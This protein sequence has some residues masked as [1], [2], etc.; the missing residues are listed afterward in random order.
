MLHFW[1]QNDPFAPNSFSQRDGKMD[2]GQTLCIFR[3]IPAGDRCP[4]NPQSKIGM[5]VSITG[6]VHL[7]IAVLGL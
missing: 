4:K 6:H 2:G 5:L 1:T 7:I 3:T